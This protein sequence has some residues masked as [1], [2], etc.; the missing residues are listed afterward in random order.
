MDH[1]NSVQELMNEKSAAARLGLSPRTLQ[2]WRV[3]GGGPIYR[4][5][6]RRVL[7][8]AADLAS[9]IDAGARSHTSEGRR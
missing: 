5:I 3:T 9:F 4:K 2:S 1:L 7:Y 6:G 8:A